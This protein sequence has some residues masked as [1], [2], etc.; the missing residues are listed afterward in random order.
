VREKRTTNKRR[1]FGGSAVVS[2]GFKSHHGYAAARSLAAR[3][4]TGR[5]DRRTSGRTDGSWS[6]SSLGDGIVRGSI[7]RACGN[8]DGDIK[9]RIKGGARAR[10]LET[11]IS[12][13]ELGTICA[14][15]CLSPGLGFNPSR[16]SRSVNRLIR[17]RHYETRD[18]NSSSNTNYRAIESR[19][20][21][22]G[23]DNRIKLRLRVDRRNIEPADK[24]FVSARARGTPD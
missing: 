10:A 2:R 17:E 4:W 18:W 12:A 1:V 7:N 5:M 11:A 22:R 13:S 8:D 3:K 20:R 9:W 6:W 14:M 23:P 24:N 19:A 16:D 15:A 21:A